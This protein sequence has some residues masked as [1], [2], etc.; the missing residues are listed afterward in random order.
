MGGVRIG[1]RWID[2]GFVALTLLGLWP[3]IWCQDVDTG[4]YS[5]TGNPSVLPLI[6]QVIYSRLSNLSTV[7]RED[8]SDRLGFCIENV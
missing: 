4:A 7:F 6:T 8:I 3:C 1:G 2:Y 5:Q